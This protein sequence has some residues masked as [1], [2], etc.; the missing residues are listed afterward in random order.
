MVEQN[1]TKTLYSFDSETENW[2]FYF[3]VCMLI[4][5]NKDSTQVF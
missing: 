2:D 4:E 5:P 1:Q 3:C